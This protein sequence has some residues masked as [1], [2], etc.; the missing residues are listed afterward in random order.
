MLPSLLLVAAELRDPS[1]K[2]LAIVARN[3]P[4]K[5]A[6]TTIK[7]HITNPTIARNFAH[8]AASDKMTS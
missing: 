6:I 4:K 3:E 7:P 2:E 5:I 1:L 8:L